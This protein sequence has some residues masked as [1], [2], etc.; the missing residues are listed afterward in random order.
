MQ[1]QEARTASGLG[2]SVTVRL[3]APDDAAAIARAHVSA[4][5]GAYRGLMP[6]DYLEAM[7]PERWAAGWVRMLAEP[8]AEQEGLA[9]AVVDG[10]VQG[11]VAYGR[12]RGGPPPTGELFAINL[13]P[14]VWGRGAGRALLRH[15]E[16]ALR[17]AGH[18]EAVLW[19]HPGNERARRFYVAHGWTDDPGTERTATVNGV[20]VPEVRYRRRLDP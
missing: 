9:V 8:P 14:E 4:W 19:V 15:A 2:A 13:A 16:E 11:F 17:A 5:R 3:A 6:D 18:P 10:T 20:T 7:D 12:D 1:E